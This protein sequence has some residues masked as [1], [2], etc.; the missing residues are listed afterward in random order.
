MPRF[1][2]SV[3]AITVSVLD[4]SFAPTPEYP[5]Y[6]V[7]LLLTQFELSINNGRLMVCF[8]AI[9]PVIITSNSPHLIERA[10]SDAL[11]PSMGLYDG[12]FYCLRVSVFCP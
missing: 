9:N 11:L 2:N 1:K 3:W 8:A 6:I 12:L 7:E 10:F 4:G 5:I